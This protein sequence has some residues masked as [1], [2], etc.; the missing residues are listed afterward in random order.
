MQQQ[1]NLSPAA[2][3]QAE[4]VAEALAKLFGLTKPNE[5]RL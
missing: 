4:K 5:Q 1:K 2:Q 3:K